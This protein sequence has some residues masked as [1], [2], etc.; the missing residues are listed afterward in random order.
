MT[1]SITQQKRERRHKRI[2]GKIHGTL[3]RPRLAVFKS[4]KYLYAELIDDERGVTLASASSLGAKEKRA[5][6][7]LLVGKLIAQA[8]H[9]KKIVSVVF[10]RGGFLY[11]GK[12]KALAEGARAAGLSF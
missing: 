9:A 3:K 6:H 5:D 2:R 11:R 4:N 12:V 1:S 7:A 10:D 8:A